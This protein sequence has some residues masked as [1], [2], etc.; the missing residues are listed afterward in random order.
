LAIATFITS[1][2]HRD[3]QFSQLLGQ[4]QICLQ[5]IR[6]GQWGHQAIAL[7]AGDYQADSVVL[8]LSLAGGN[9]TGIG[10]SEDL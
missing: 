6:P 7:D 5:A 8:E 4:Q 3:L 9:Q 1:N 2:K 10:R